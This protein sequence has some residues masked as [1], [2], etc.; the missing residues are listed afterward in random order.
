[1]PLPASWGYRGSGS[2][3]SFGTEP[4]NRREDALCR[5]AWCEHTFVASQGSAHGRFARAIKDENLFAAEL[6]ARELRGLSLH[7]ALDLVALIARQR[8]DR[9]ER[10]AIRWHGRLEIEAP[11]LTLA[12]SRFALAALE[13]MPADPQAADLLRKLLRRAS[14]TTLRPFG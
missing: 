4:A 6:A 12:E 3:S 11:A 8:P 5:L 10:A 1:M 13:R 9:L 7:D 14:P 2:F